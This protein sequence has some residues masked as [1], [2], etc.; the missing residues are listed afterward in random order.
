MKDTVKRLA[1]DGF[2]REIRGEAA[3]PFVSLA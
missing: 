1:E 2:Q 3:A